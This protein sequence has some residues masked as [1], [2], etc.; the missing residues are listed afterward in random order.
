MLTLI[1]STTYAQQPP[2]GAGQNRQQMARPSV[3]ETAKAQ[4]D[5]MKEEL[6]LN[7]ATVTKVTAVVTKYTQAQQDEISKVM[8][9]GGNFESISKITTEQNAKMDAELKP[10]LGDATFEKYAKIAA[11]KR[12]ARSPMGPRQ[13]GQPSGGQPGGN[14]QGPPP[15]N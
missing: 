8:S 13:G 14:Q 2:A 12:A 4:V 10:I 6:Q 9:S 7:E 11:E 5:W 1:A 15:T 3:E